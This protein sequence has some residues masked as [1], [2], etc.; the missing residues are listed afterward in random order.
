LKRVWVLIT[1]VAVV[2]AVSFVAWYL[3]NNSQ[4]DT[5]IGDQE[6]VFQVGAFKPFAQGEYDGDVT[7]AELAKHGDFG[8]GTF[9]GLDGEMGALGGVFYQVP[10]DGVPVRTSDT[11]ETPFALVTYF[12]AD[13]TVHV[14]EAMNY[15]ELKV[16]VDQLISPEDALYA[17]KISGD[18]S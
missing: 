17:I 12:E 10:I 8:L 3:V 1:L 14:T 5:G 6:T 2:A 13:K 18:Y 15:S 11:Q 16:Y 4:L 9:N 7:Y